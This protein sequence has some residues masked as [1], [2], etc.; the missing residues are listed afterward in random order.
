MDPGMR[1]PMTS[2]DHRPWSLVEPRDTSPTR[3]VG[4]DAHESLKATHTHTKSR[5]HRLLP[6]TS[7]CCSAPPTPG[8]GGGTGWRLGGLMIVGSAHITPSRAQRCATCTP[9]MGGAHGSVPVYDGAP[10]PRSGV[11]CSSTPTGVRGGS[12]RT[13]RQNYS[14]STLCTCFWLD[15]ARFGS[16]WIMFENF[17]LIYP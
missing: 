1:R 14:S 8:G 16:I 4:R 15:L 6:A 7:T 2:P 17:R 10:Q 13:G 12:Y 3:T 5:R 9:R 11:R